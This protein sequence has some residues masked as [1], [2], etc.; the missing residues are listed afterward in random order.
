[1]AIGLVSP[2]FLLC[3]FLGPGRKLLA[4]PHL[5][6][7]GEPLVDWL[8]IPNI[9]GRMKGA[10]EI[11]SVVRPLEPDVGISFRVAWAASRDIFGYTLLAPALPSPI[12]LTDEHQRNSRGP[13]SG[14]EPTVPCRLSSWP[15]VSP[16]GP[17]PALPQPQGP[18][19]Q[20]GPC[21]SYHKKRAF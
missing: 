20:P 12:R 4:V 2:K 13:A 19:S 21:H 10:A 3:S 1:M 8:W 6:V 9:H 7:L 15:S 16:F 18:T 11:Q 17:S 14:P 5:L